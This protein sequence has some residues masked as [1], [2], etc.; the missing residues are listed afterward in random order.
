MRKSNTQPLKS[1]LREYIE[2]LGHRRKLK[3]VNL[4]TSWENLMG[5]AISN[6]TKNIYIK[7]KTLFVKLDS[8]V[9][10][11]ELLMNREKIIDHL[12]SHAGE[13]II[14]KIIFQ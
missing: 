9:L 2:A 7:N 13:S 4:I 3:E 10:K 5:K 8:S 14:E 1:V 11:N 6:H 12:N